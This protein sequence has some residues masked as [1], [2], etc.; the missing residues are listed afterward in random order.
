MDVVYFDQLTGAPHTVSW[1][2]SFFDAKTSFSVFFRH[3]CKK[4]A[5]I[6]KK[7]VIKGGLPALS[8]IFKPRVIPKSWSVPGKNS[9]R[10]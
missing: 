8:V 7:R 6:T 10:T 4:N 9:A 1:L 3:K 2:K 5:K